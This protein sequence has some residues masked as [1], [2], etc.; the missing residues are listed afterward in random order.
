MKRSLRYRPAPPS[1]TERR[2]MAKHG[3]SQPLAKAIAELNGGMP[4]K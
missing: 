1:P 2:L 3:F 4:R